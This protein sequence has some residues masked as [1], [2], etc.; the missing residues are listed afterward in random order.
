M[1]RTFNDLAAEITGQAPRRLLGVVMDNTKANNAAMAILQELHPYWLVFGC[2]G[3][4]LALILKDFANE[5]KCPWS[6]KVFDRAINI[7]NVIGDSEKIRS[8]VIE[9]QQQVYDKV[10]GQTLVMG[11]CGGGGVEGGVLH[12]FSS[13]RSECCMSAHTCSTSGSCFAVVCHVYSL[14]ARVA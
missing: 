5:N 11:G 10:G 1:L 4:A 9:K 13:A 14:A 2:Q 6:A 12:W 3:H 8:L 7:S